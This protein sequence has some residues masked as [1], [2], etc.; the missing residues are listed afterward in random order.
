MPQS[1]Y[2]PKRIFSNKTGNT[3]K[4]RNTETDL[5]LPKPKKEFGKMCFVHSGA[6]L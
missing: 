4:L 2:G 6:K 3:Y 1:I 5:A